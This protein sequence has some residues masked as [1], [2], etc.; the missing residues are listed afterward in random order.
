M[1]INNMVRRVVFERAYETM[2][3]Y[4]IDSF[5]Y[6]KLIERKEEIMKSMLDYYE[7]TEEFEKCS[8]IVEFFN[9]INNA[10]IPKES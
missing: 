8:Y 1:K 9:K 6:S 7:S 3:K 2:N 4:G 5:I 10:E